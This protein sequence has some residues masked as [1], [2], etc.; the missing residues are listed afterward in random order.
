M[1]SVRAAGPRSVLTCSGSKSV[2]PDGSDH[3]MDGQDRNN[4]MI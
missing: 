4:D 2:Q 3:K 1:G